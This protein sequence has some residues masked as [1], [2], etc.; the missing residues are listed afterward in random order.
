MLF[1]ASIMKM[2]KWEERDEK[3]SRDTYNRCGIVTL[4]Q[5]AGTGVFHKA[6]VGNGDGRGIIRAF[7]KMV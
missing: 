5:C 6:G 4:R 7:G 3:E 2:K 1:V